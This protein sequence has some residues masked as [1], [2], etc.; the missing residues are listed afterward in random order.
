M[1]HHDPL[2]LLG[3][4][5]QRFDKPVVFKAPKTSSKAKSVSQDTNPGAQTRHKKPLTSSKQHFMS[6]KEATKGV[7]SEERANPQLNSNQTKS[8]SEGLETVLIQLIIRKGAYS[9]ANQIEEKTSNTVKLE[10]LAKLVSHVQPSFKDLDL[11]KDDPFIVVNDSDE[12]KDDEVHATENVKAQDTSSQKYQLE[13]KKN[14]AEAK[15]ALLKAQPSFLNV[16]QLKELLVKSLKTEFSNILSAHDFSSSLPTE[17]KD[18]PSEFNDLTEEELLAEFLAVPSQVETVQGQA[19]TQPAK[20]EKNTNPN[21]FSKLFQRRA[22]KEHLNKQQPKL[23]APPTIPIIITTTTQ[24]QSPFLQRSPKG[25]S[26]T[27]GEHIKKDKGKRPYL[28]KRQ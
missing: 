8:I 25:S 9:V 6:N 21:T 15:D 11:P 5:F 26:Q 24:M 23:T 3:S 16:Q 2:M 22:K 10:D 13:L 28:L 12:D 1:L 4:C 14:K 27:E 7:T 19:G 17:L 18:L 20:G